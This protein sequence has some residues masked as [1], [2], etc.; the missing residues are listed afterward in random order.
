[1]YYSE[2]LIV[3][4]EIASVLISTIDYLMTI[5]IITFDTHLRIIHIKG[6]PHVLMVKGDPQGIGVSE[7]AKK[8]FF[9]V[10]RPLRRK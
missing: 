9:L 4:S 7:A 5:I 10:V 6:V 1:M 8:L 3:D 2:Y